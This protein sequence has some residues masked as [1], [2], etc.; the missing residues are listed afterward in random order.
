MEAYRPNA[1]FDAHHDDPEFGR[2]FLSDE[3]WD[4]GAAMSD[5][6]AWRIASNNGWFCAFGK[7]DRRKA[8]RPGPPAHDNLRAVVDEHGRTRHVFAA[9]APNELCLTDVTEHKTAEGHLYLYAIKE[10]LSGQ[11]V[12]YSIDLRTKSCL[13]VR[14]LENAAL[15]RA[16]VVG[17]VVHSDR[18]DLPPSPMSS[19]SGPFDADQVLDHHE[20]DRLTAGVTTDCH[21]SAQQSRWMQS[22]RR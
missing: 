21:L 2:R 10:V 8:R 14:A 6:T 16:D 20:H 12:G 11:T 17:C 19:P 15:M 4:A 7:P 5:W 18:A 9:D 3:A 22:M 1:S 13:A